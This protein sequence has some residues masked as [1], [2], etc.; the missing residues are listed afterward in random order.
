MICS[1][2]SKLLKLFIIFDT[3]NYFWKLYQCKKKGKGRDH[4][5][6]LVVLIPVVAPTLP[7]S[8]AISA[9][10]LDFRNL[11]LLIFYLQGIDYSHVKEIFVHWKL[12]TLIFPSQYRGLTDFRRGC[13]SRFQLRIMIGFYEYYINAFIAEQ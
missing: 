11:S 10:L 12:L 13:E 6:T 3:L 2:L 7:F 5:C 8:S 1:W 4:V 9:A